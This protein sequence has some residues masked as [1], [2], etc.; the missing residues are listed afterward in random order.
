MIPTP[1]KRTYRGASLAAFVALLLGS[2]TAMAG[3]TPPA[4]AP[5]AAD[6]TPNP[7]ISQI[8]ALNGDAVKAFTAYNFATGVGKLR[9]ALILAQ[10]HKLMSDKALAP[11]Y[12]LL[13]MGVVAQKDDL[14]R[15]LHYFTRALRLKRHVGMPKALVTPQILRVYR[16]AKQA[17]HAIGT[18][19]SIKLALHAER[20]Q[21]ALDTVKKDARGIVHEVVDEVKRGLPIPVKAVAGVDIRATKFFLYFRAA[22]K[23]KYQRLPMKLSR[24]AYRGAIPAKFTKG[25]YVHYYIEARDQRGRI[26]ASHGSARG[27]NVVTTKYF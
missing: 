3:P 16:S 17:V 9:Q 11:T 13:G 24:G 26:A 14:Y 8:Q 18:P 5:A 10:E 27:P 1:A 6:A 22:G 23:V 7:V 20:V 4:K 12:I 2:A 19:P 21:T 25:R 15:G